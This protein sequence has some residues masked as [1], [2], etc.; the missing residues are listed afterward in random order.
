MQIERG[1]GRGLS[2]APPGPG[3]AGKRPKINDFR[4]YPPPQKKHLKTRL[5]ASEQSS[6]SR[7]PKIDGSSERPS[8]ARRQQLA[9]VEDPVDPVSKA[10]PRERRLTTGRTLGGWSGVARPEIVDFMPSPAKPGPKKPWNRLG[11]GPRSICNKFQPRRPILR[12][13]RLQCNHKGVQKTSRNGLRLG[14]PG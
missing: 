1:P 13:C 2:Q 5:T 4:S 6:N 9:R 7:Q 11:P 3:W 8:P 14:Q 12:P 10:S